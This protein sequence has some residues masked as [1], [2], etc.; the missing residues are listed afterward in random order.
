MV[1]W[2]IFF[3]VWVGV[4]WGFFQCVFGLVFFSGL[5]FFLV[6]CFVGGFFCVKQVIL[7]LSIPYG[8]I[9]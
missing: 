2:G 9:R 3:L 1:F 7:N 6:F 4:W 8:S 5:G